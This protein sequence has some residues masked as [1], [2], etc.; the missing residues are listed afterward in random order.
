MTKDEFYP[1]SNTKISTDLLKIDIEHNLKQVFIS[2]NLHNKTNFF[3]HRREGLP[4]KLITE[5]FLVLV[6]RCTHNTVHTFKIPL[7][8]VI[9]WKIVNGVGDGAFK[10]GYGLHSKY[11]DEY[12][13]SDCVI[14]YPPNE[15]TRKGFPI[16]KIS[17]N[18][19]I[20]TSNSNKIINDL[21][22]MT[23]EIKDFKIERFTDCEFTLA[24]NIKRKEGLL[25]KMYYDV[26]WTC[27]EIVNEAKSKKIINDRDFSKEVIPENNF[28]YTYNAGNSKIIYSISKN[29]QICKYCKLYLSFE[30][31]RPLSY[32]PKMDID[33]DRIFTSEFINICKRYSDVENTIHSDDN[34][35]VFV[36][37]DDHDFLYKLRIIDCPVIK[38]SR[39]FW[40]VTSGSFPCGNEGN[41]IIYRSSE[42]KELSKSPVTLSLYEKNVFV[43]T[44]GDSL[45]CLLDQRKLWLMRRLVFGG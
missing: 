32:K 12:C 29:K 18:I 23:S 44:E 40:N 39:T 28:V 13:G 1:F 22:L 27:E 45:P 21:N 10:H 38:F 26:S 20:K 31:C 41:S 17:I 42:E 7:E 37:K 9:D 15:E 34:S 35:I 16:K 43:N 11:F 5:S 36:I 14:Y 4:I 24:L 33:T 30:Y 2:D 19:K 8:S 25:K 3:F 6:I